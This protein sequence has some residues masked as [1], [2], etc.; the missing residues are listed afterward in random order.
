M[1][2]TA[3]SNE[4]ADWDDPTENEVRIVSGAFASALGGPRH[5]TDLQAMS[6]AAITHSMTGYRFDLHSL[7]QTSPYELATALAERAA[8]WRTRI[9]H[10]MLIGA[11]LL[12]KIP[13]E[14]Q[15]RLE[16]YA[17]ALGVHDDMLSL[18]RQLAAGSLTAAME[19]FQRSGYEGDWTQSDALQTSQ[20]LDSAWDVVEDDASLAAR[21]AEL[22][23]CPTGSLGRGVFDILRRPWLFVPGATRLGA[24]AARST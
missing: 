14:I 22:A 8:P 9:L 1:T 21:W 24:T 2:N 6:I 20:Q 3:P 23:E 5:L 4:A 10:V 17:D 13:P 16:A 18:T 11:L 7:P 12:E 15:T 19:D